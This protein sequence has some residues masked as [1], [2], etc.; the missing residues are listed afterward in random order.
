MIT[1]VN[2]GPLSL[3]QDL[4]RPQQSHLGVPRSGAADRYAL[5]LANR[6]VGNRE[7]AAGIEAVLGGL[8]VSTDTATWV[9]VTGAPTEI[10]VND[11][12]TAS[13]TVIHLAADDR[14]TVRT[15]PAGLR[16]Y[17]AVRGGLEVEPVLG[18]RSTDTLSKIGPPAL[19]RGQRIG[20][21]ES[22]RPVPGVEF[23]P[24]LPPRT[25]LQISPGPRRDW[26]TDSAWQALLASTWTVTSDSDRVALRLNGPSLGRRISDELPSEGLRRGA[27]QVPA[28]G[29][30]I[31]FGPD[32]P[33][34]GGYPVIAVLT[35]RACDH[36]AQARPGDRL[37]FTTSP[38]LHHRGH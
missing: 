11:T 22:D 17:L 9:A 34:T 23:A 27:I 38:Q 28:S 4:G 13:H 1:V 36:A 10:W 21:G 12:P 37:T 24:S 18:S 16:T 6:L 3:V 19:V 26:F 31:V 30:P 7:D 14:L 33:V 32:H 29:Q 35:E 15:P 8:Q 5:T 20:V 25:R 2:P